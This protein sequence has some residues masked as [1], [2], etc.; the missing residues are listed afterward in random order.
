MANTYKG[1]CRRDFIVRLSALAGAGAVAR[2]GL[3]RKSG[4]RPWAELLERTFAVDVA[5]GQ[6]LRFSSA[7]VARGG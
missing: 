7:P 3:A 2:T 1:P 6:T 5:R 4:Y